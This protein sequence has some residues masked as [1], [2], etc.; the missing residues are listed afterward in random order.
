MNRKETRERVLEAFPYSKRWCS[1]LELIRAYRA[2][3]RCTAR[4]G[5]LWAGNAFVQIGARKQKVGK[6]W[7]FTTATAPVIP[8]DMCGYEEWLSIPED[9][10]LS[11]SI[12]GIEDQTDYN[13]AMLLGAL[14]FSGDDA[15]LNS[16]EALREK[17]ALPEEETVRGRG[18]VIDV[19][20][21]GERGAKRWE[22][23]DGR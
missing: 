12:E 20:T 17:Y 1:V 13:H 16:F 11:H 7:W 10:R 9:W 23:K 4:A 3:R 18:N 22:N 5:Y 14:A 8:V 21:L 2:I 19:L 6:R 15:A